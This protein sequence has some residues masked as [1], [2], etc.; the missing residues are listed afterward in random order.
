MRTYTMREAVELTGLTHKA[1]QHRADR[2]TLP[3]FLREGQR[4]V[5][6]QALEAAGLLPDGETRRLH[7]R[8]DELERELVTHRQLVVSTAAARKAEEEARGRAELATF[9]ARAEADGAAVREAVERAA[10]ERAESDREKLAGQLAAWQQ[11]GWRERRRLR[12]SGPALAEQ[13]VSHL[14][15]R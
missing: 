14:S 9:E 10:R 5:T 6:E 3:V 15:T 2:G 8:V 1:L 4:R 7:A 13:L 12:R 11:A